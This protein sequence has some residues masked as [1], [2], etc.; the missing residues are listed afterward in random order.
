MKKKQHIYQYKLFLLCII[1]TLIGCRGGGSSDSDDGAVLPLGPADLVAI[2]MS[3]SQID[4]TWTDRSWNESGFRIERSANGSNFT[5]AGTTESGVTNYSNTGLSPATV[6]YYR[7]YS[8]NA[9]GNSEFSNTV[10]ATTQNPPVT[11]PSAPSGLSATTISSSQIDLNWTDN[12]NNEEGF[13]IERGTDGINYTE[14][15]TVTANITV[16]SNSGLSGGTTYH[17]RIR[18]YNSIGNSSYSNTTQASTG[19]APTSSP[20][21][22]SDHS[23]IAVSSSQI[24]LAWTDNSNNED[25]FK[26]ERSTDGVIFSQIA[27]V[28][29]NIT[30]FGNIGLSPST[31]YYYRIRAYNSI[32][33]S[34]YS[35]TAQATTSATPITIPSDPSNLTATTVSSI[36]INLNWTDNSDN[37]EGFKIERSTD[38][39]N[40]AQITTVTANTTSYNNTGLTA[41]TTYYYRTRAY[42]SAGNSGFSNIAN[43]TTQAPP[44]TIPTAPSNLVAAAASSKQIDL[45]WEDNSNNEDSFKVERGKDGIQFSQIALLGPNSKVY[46]DLN[47]DPST[48]YYY[49]VRASNSA[50]DSAYTNIAFATTHPESQSVPAAPTSLVATAMSS[51]KIKLT[52]VDN[53]NNE[54]GFKIERS[55]DGINFRQINTVLANTATYTDSNLR[56]NTTYYYRVRAYNIIGNSVYSNIASAKTNSGITNPGSDPDFQ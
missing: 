36:Q 4:L 35:N 42:N 44:V 47:L 16:F 28:S 3:S 19:P 2:V 31:M 49:R 14:I 43:A 24:N 39:V 20:N 9:S 21:A 34:A 23:A 52:W 48:T 46:S 18:S 22:P 37:E 25:G 32:G 41:S 33:N 40:F 1:T 26:I 55:E 7:V 27:T 54:D 51:S 38:G 15:A 10:Q 45:I 30:I 29:P 5:E 11:A 17:Y 50:G 53:S 13:R 6:Y 56:A 12:S 8:Y